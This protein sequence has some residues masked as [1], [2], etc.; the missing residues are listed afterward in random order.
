MGNHFRRHI[1]GLLLRLRNVARGERDPEGRR[2]E[3]GDEEEVMKWVDSDEFDTG[4]GYLPTWFP[5]PSIVILWVI[6]LVIAALIGGCTTPRELAQ[7]ASWSNLTY[8]NHKYL[9]VMTDNSSG[10]NTIL[11]DPDCLCQARGRRVSP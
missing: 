2:P 6:T 10:N 4:E 1:D 3:G 8:K 11:H 9:I 5:R 7:K